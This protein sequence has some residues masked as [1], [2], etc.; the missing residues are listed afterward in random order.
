M[1]GDERPQPRIRS[2]WTV[3]VWIIALSL[4]LTA[5]S[6]V[7]AQET[8]TIGVVNLAP[9]LDGIVEGVSVTRR[10]QQ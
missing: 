9:R 4:P 6:K 8:Y 7:P 3:F 5:C 10:G 1:L 2:Q